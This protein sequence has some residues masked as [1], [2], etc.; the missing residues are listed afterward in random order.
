MI[1]IFLYKQNS[2]QFIGNF[3]IHTD[4]VHISSKTDICSNNTNC[5][6]PFPVLYAGLHR[7]IAVYIHSPPNALLFLNTNPEHSLKTVVGILNAMTYNY[8]YCSCGD[9]H[10]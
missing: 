8:E 10:L 3:N 9:L 5:T 4:S 6:L 1:V 7:V 2:L